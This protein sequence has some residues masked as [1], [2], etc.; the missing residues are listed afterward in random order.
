MFE[1]LR[2]NWFK[3]VF[4]KDLGWIQVFLKIF[5][6]ILMHSIYK[7][8]C[9]EEFPHKIALFLKNFGFS[10]FSIDRVWFSINQ[11]ILDFSSLASAWLDWYTIDAQSIETK[12]FSVFKYLTNLFFLHHL[13]LG[14]TCIA[15]FSI[16][17]MQ[18]CS[19]ISHCF[20]TYHAFT[21]LNWVLNL[22]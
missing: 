11:K 4:L 6:L 9:F 19:H 17:I 10:I 2:T 21:L 13:C 1:L 5:H 14:F 16:S 3:N 20:Q 22:I 15:L 8:L 7:I 18:F 12:K